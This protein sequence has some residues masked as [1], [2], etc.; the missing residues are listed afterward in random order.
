MRLLLAI[1]LSI[2]LLGVA[3]VER[4]TLPFGS[5][6]I[7]RRDPTVATVALELWFRAPSIGYDEPTPGFARYAATAVAASRLAGGHTLSDVIKSLGGR[8]AISDYP[9][10]VA[11]AV[12]VP[13]GSEAR[14]LKAMTTAYFSPV[15]SADGMHVALRD[16]V[17][18]GTQRHFDPEGTLRDAVFAQLFTDGPAHFSTLPAAAQGLAHVTL[19]NLRTFAARAFRS[20][21]AVITIA[22][23]ANFDVSG[24][25][26]GARVDGQTMQPP[27]D[28]TPA[29]GGGSGSGAFA[30]DAIGL[31]WTGPPIS[32]PKAAT[33][34][35]FIADYLF[36]PD[37]GLVAKTLSASDPDVFMNGTFVTL[38]NPGV[39]LVQ[40]AGKNSAP[41]R[42][43]VLSA[44]EKMRAPMDARAF[45]AA[46][47]AFEYHILTDSQT[48]LGQADNFGWYTIEGDP[49]YSPAD[50][51]R[52]Y[53]KI[54][55]T[56]DA[57][58]VAKVARQYLGAPAVVELKGTQK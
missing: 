32:D 51:S 11:I 18:A 7:M 46:R 43:E 27:I 17:I 53:L 29:P 10:A 38:H 9:D 33:A 14:V 12:S 50:D 19:E 23:N 8:F 37:V 57:A 44:V 24:A 30:E 45:A 13:A 36:R 26:G 39:M 31:G 6:V 54:A 41:A 15:L 25:I 1:C 48:P 58:Y 28:S 42:D 2:S 52:R 22:G 40:I 21:N 16:V 56:L 55:D 47:A 4:S 5:Q 20:S 35:D 3:P 49:S 34:L